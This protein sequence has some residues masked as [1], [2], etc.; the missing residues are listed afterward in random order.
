MTH[1]NV[2]ETFVRHFNHEIKFTCLLLL[3]FI[4]NVC[5]DGEVATLD[6][7]P[8]LM[9]DQSIASQDQ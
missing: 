2:N 7:L 5:V 6:D 9:A 4:L 1:N 8:P 3:T